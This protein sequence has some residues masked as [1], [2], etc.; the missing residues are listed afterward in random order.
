MRKWSKVLCIVGGLLIC[1]TALQAADNTNP[2]ADDKGVTTLSKTKTNTNLVHG[3]PGLTP[4]NAALKST[5]QGFTAQ[6]TTMALE[7]GVDS[8]TRPKAPAED[9]LSGKLRCPESAI[10]IEIFTDNYPGETTWEV[11]EYPSMAV[12]C[13]GGPYATANFLYTEQ[14]C[15][16]DAGCYHFVIYDSYGDGICCAYGN[17][18]YNVS[19]NAAPVCNGGVFGSADWCPCIGDQ[20][21]PDCGLTQA[22]CV[23][24]ICYDVDDQAECDAM[25][26]DYYA[27]EMCSSFVCPQSC[28]PDTTI[29][30]QVTDDCSGSWS[31]ATSGMGAGGPPVG[32]WYR[33]FENFPSLGDIVEIQDIHWWGLLLHYDGGWYDCANPAPVQ[34]LIQFWA[35]DAGMPADYFAGPPVCTNGPLSPSYIALG[36]ACGGFQLYYFWVDPLDPH[37]LA[38]SGLPGWVSIES[39][40]NSPDPDCVFLWMSAGSGMSLQWEVGSGIPPADTGKNRGLCLTG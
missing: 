6:F 38:F 1:T 20:C 7:T 4:E 21:P 37:C 30:G 15:V 23:G 17:G 2:Q 12:V 14:C 40:D 13:S 9:T 10:D 18:Y 39:T 24:N 22:C 34:F 8:A 25:G 5:A 26:G 11:L 28:P 29:F 31:A 16:L 36:G 35:D 3:Q 32:F 33:V 27:N 19:Y